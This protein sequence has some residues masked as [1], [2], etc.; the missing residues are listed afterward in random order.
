MPVSD[1]DLAHLLRRTE[2]V[3][4][5]ARLA[6]LKTLPSIV[7]V[8][9]D[10]INISLN[11]SPALPAE[12]QVEGTNS[13]DQYVSACN[14]WINAMVTKPRPFQEKMTLFWHGHFVSAW[15]DVGKG[16]H[17]MQQLQT[18]RDNALGNFHTLTQAMAIDRA[19]LVYLSNA[20]NVKGSPNQNF[21]RELMELFTLGVGNYTEGDVEAA[22]KAWTGHNADWPAYV[23]QFY[24]TRH[25]NTMKTFFGTTKNW[26]GPDIITEILV[27]NAAK[28]QIAA[29][30]ITKKLW[31][32]LAHPTPPVAVL[33]AL[34]PAFAADMSIT[35]LVR[36]MLKRPEFYSTT[37]KQG[38]VRT[39]IEM[40]VALCYYTGIDA[41][42]LGVAWRAESAGQQMYQPPNVAGWK[43]NAYWLNTSALAGRADF[44]RSM[45][46][47]LRDGNAVPA[48]PFVDGNVIYNKT[49]ADAVDF[50]ASYFGIFPLS[51]TTRNALI[52]AH[53]AERSSTSY[54]N[55]WAPT[56]LLTM[57]MLAPEFH[58][59]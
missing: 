39:P 26:N 55:Y 52:A 9:D 3:V 44:A 51:T 45:T 53:Q 35:N 37:A 40:I 33:D 23:Y 42:D 5:P 13:W 49:V 34:V 22:A 32:F 6:Y 8:V 41:D 29:R 38:L 12:F 10:V 21:A 57:V 31:E 50:V 17:M 20:E 7:E 11:G 19:M 43:P 54:R 18:Y 56:N 28:K 15:W 25:D 4:R 48:R 16:F 30:F 58:M 1:D 14:F 59:A 46:W 27:N 36:E 47:W 24:P 2:F